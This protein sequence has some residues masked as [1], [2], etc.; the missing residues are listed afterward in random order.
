MTSSRKLLGAAAFSL[1]LAGGGAAG[2]LLGTPS[3]SGAQDTD[4]TAEA[5]PTDARAVGH[6]GFGG[7]GGPRHAFGHPGLDAA[8]EVI[9][10]TAEELEAELQAGRSMAEVAEAN[11]V[12]PQA[13]IDALVASGLER[14]Q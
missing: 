6:P 13:V 3:T 9:G 5:G 14:L 2:A 8:A 7:P 1:A 10:I 4:T 11:D 12:E